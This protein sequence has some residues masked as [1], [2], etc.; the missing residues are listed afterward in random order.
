MF[1]KP[2]ESIQNYTFAKAKNKFKILLK[3]ASHHT[4][5]T[6][7]SVISLSIPQSPGP[8]LPNL[9]ACVKQ[10]SNPVRKKKL[11]NSFIACLFTF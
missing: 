7:F 1:L 2:P 5:V 9:G 10:K 6:N 11:G 3:K 4:S 8:K